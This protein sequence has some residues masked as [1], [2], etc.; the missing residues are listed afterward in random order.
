MKQLGTEPTLV[1]QY[2]DWHW[3]RF[4]PKIGKFV[5]DDSIANCLDQGP[6]QVISA[7]VL[8]KTCKEI[9][10]LFESDCTHT[11]LRELRYLVPGFATYITGSSATVAN[12][13]KI[14]IVAV[15][16]L[17]NCKRALYIPSPVQNLY[18]ARHLR[19]W[20]HRLVPAICSWR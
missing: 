17:R 16:Q 15:G 14:E 5:S 18:Y 3:R 7:A 9:N 13:Q 6:Q 10:N 20:L 1:M 11:M 8:V 4:D 12:G 2:P 19:A